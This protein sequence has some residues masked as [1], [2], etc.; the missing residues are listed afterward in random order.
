MPRHLL[1]MAVFV[2][3][4]SALISPSRHTATPVV[5]ASAAAQAPATSTMADQTELAVTV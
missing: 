4:G 3:A 2:L 5:S 1:T